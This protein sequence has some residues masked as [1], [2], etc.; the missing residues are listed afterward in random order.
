MGSGAPRS[1]SLA[2]ASSG[3]AT[4]SPGSPALADAGPA[5]SPFAPAAQPARSIPTRA[6]QMNNARRI[7]LSLR[8]GLKFYKFVKVVKIVTCSTNGGK[9][10]RIPLYLPLT[11]ARLAVAPLQGGG[12]RPF[13]SLVGVLATLPSVP[14]A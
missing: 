4:A 2:A 12:E 14:S 11:P 13:G 7:R 6:S 3:W 8:Y 1:G 10:S 5:G 9:M